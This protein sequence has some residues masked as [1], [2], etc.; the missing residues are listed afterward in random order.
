M[1]IF[2]LMLKYRKNASIISLNDNGPISFY[3]H[4]HIF[5]FTETSVTV[6]VDDLIKNKHK[7]VAYTRYLAHRG[8]W[9]RQGKLWSVI[10]GARIHQPLL[11]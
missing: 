11:R 1:G 6:L 8:E 9:V 4:V 7:T 10:L 5:L 3:V 2:S